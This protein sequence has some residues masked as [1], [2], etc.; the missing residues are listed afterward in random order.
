MQ[1]SMVTCNHCD[2]CVHAY[3]P[4]AGQVNQRYA[5]LAMYATWGSPA[6]LSSWSSLDPCDGSW[7]GITCTGITVV[8]VTL[9]FMSLQRRLDPAVGCLTGLQTL[10]LYGTG[11]TGTLPGTL[12]LLSRLTLLGMWHNA[13]TGSI[14]PEFSLMV[15]LQELR[16]AW[17]SVGGT[18]PQQLSALTNLHIF[19]VMINRFTGTIPPQLSAL[20]SVWFMSLSENQ[21]RGFIPR[22]LSALVNMA[23]MYLSTNVLT[24][25]I[26]EQLSTLQKLTNF[27]LGKNRLTGSLPMALSSIFTRLDPWSVMS[28]GLCGL[29]TSWP[30]V[31]I[32]ATLLGRACQITPTQKLPPLSNGK[33]CI[34]TVICIAYFVSA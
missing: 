31:Q 4:A 32:D 20:T 6:S 1:H 9:N 19:D 34:F 8:S 23:S 21:L 3:Y 5:L 2:S 28:N 24:G 25:G 17:N 29:R 14:P 30:N 18:I 13:L 22:Q 7:I 15:N 27:Q 26:P 11:L 10:S 16:M 33:G 12:S